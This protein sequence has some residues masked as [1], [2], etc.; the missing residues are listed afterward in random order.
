M[1]SVDS[2]ELHSNLTGTKAVA[3]G[4]LVVDAAR[5]A[6]LFALHESMI[7]G[8]VQLHNDSERCYA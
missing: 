7:G 5:R 2:Y 4:S 8:I 3:T 1:L 6:P